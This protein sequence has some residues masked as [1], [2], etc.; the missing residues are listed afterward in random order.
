MVLLP[1]FC[2]WEF[3]LLFRGKFREAFRRFAGKK[4]AK[5][6]IEGTYFRCWYYNPSFIKRKLKNDF[7]VAA[8]E[9][10]CT[11][12]PPSYIENFAEKHP[13]WYSRLVKKENKWKSRWPWR[14]VGDYYIITLKRK[15]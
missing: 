14:S 4:G 8:L 10:L 1:K 13:R 2:L 15:K 12:V 6:H 3:L 5:A 11:L 9:G 7:D